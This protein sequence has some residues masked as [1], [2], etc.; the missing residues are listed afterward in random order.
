VK[1]S[2]EI[3]KDATDFGCQTGLTGASSPKHSNVSAL[4]PLAP[5]QIS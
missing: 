5:L 1:I 3:V 4:H 2:S